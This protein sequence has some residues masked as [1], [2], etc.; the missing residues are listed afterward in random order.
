[1]STAMSLFGVLCAALAI[2]VAQESPYV[3]TRSRTVDVPLETAWRR[4]VGLVKSAPV[5][6]N[7][8][9]S[10][11]HIITFTM[12]LSPASVKDLA[13]DA[14]EIEKQPLTMHV[15]VWISAAGENSR[16]YIRAV[17]NGGGFFLHSN[18]QTELHLLDAIEKDGQW[19]STDEGD[20]S[21]RKLDAAPQRAQD[22]ALGVVRASKQLTLNTASADPAVLTLSLMLPSASLNQFIVKPTKQEYP[23]A[24][25]VTLW[26]DPSGSGS[27]LRM[28]TLILEDGSLSPVPLASNG[29]LESAIG[30]PIQKRLGGSSDAI[31][32]VGSNYR[33][34]QEF[35]NV[36]FDLDAPGKNPGAARLTRELPVPVE[37]SWAAVLQAVAQTNTVVGADRSAGTLTFVVAHTSQVGTRYSVHRVI[38]ALEPTTFGSAMSISIPRSQETAEESDDELRLYAERVGTDLFLKSRLK[39]L[40][41]TKE[42]KQ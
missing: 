32:A 36:L 12:P 31:V 16:L 17:P 39:W 25:H 27:V 26:F 30:D 42:V 1:M 7:A 11:S 15:T 6:V 5:I 20:A 29:R 35:W 40:T 41:G 23:G 19:I 18:G 2:A 34:K 37:Q 3:L 28:R 13:L 8:V 22:I 4:C 33:G 38:I 9:D 14:K 21:R 10:L 24:A